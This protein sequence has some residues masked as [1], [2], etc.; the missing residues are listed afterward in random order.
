M[1]DLL[2]LFQKEWR[3]NAR[4]YKVL[5]IP[6][7]FIFF[8]ITEPVTYYYLPQILEAVGNIPEDA[9]FPFPEM[10]PAQVLMSTMG[11]YQFIGMLVLVLGFMGTI[12]RERKNGTGTLIYVRPIS[13]LSYFLSKW[14]V[15]SIIAIGSVWLG[16]LTSW[17][18]TGLLFG[19][20]PA[21]NFF[22]FVGTYSVWILFV[23]SIVLAASAWLPTGGAAG[24]SL[25]LVL[26]IQ[27]IDSLLGKYW[28]VS[29]WKISI[30]A[31][32]WLTESPEAGDFWWSIAVTIG[33][34]I[35]LIAFGVWMSKRNA[36]KTKV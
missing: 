23:V 17:Y 21:S 18:Y 1:S 14:K 3:E 9:M 35:A 7:I 32:Q 33:A 20:V 30:Y 5:W 28:T 27:I 11:Q 34:I 26:V 22:A 13:F 19:D 36:S 25:G 4:N 8:G 10:T 2:V 16:L 24:V 29:P 12:S 15:V 31:T 6:L